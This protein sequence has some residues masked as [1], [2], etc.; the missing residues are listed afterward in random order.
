MR[1]QAWGRTP[2]SIGI[3]IANSGKLNIVSSF[4]T[5][6][7]QNAW[8]LLRRLAGLS[9]RNADKLREISGSGFYFPCEFVG[10]QIN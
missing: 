1:E 4:Q 9:I 8:I 2:V 7:I 10:L 5:F 3:S 6:G